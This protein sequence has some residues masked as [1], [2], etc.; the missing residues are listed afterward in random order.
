MK[1]F[2][3]ALVAAIA[4]PLAGCNDAETTAA[5]PMTE[6]DAANAE[7]VAMTEEAA[8]HHH[9]APHGGDL[10]ELGPHQY[11]LELVYPDGDMM[12]VY[13]L[14]PHASE[15]VMVAAEDIELELDL[16]G[17]EEKEVELTAV[18]PVDGKASKFTAPASEFGGAK[19]LGDIEAHVHVTI[20]GEKFDGALDHTGHDHG[21]DHE[22][23]GHDHDG[24]AVEEVPVD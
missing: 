17:G 20:E 13:T 7:A 11:N 10:I 1:R 2:T 6:A 15:P 8:G 12:T 16:E 22:G 14:G 23:E 24:D 4:L 21:H 9:T 18:D 3:P 19:T 5:K